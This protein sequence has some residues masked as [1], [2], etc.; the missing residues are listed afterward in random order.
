MIFKEDIEKVETIH[1]NL[2]EMFVGVLSQK[3]ELPKNFFHQQIFLQI[4]LQNL[5]IQFKTLFTKLASKNLK[6]NVF[7]LSMIFKEDIEKVETIHRNL[8]EMFVGVLSQ[9]K[10]LPKNFFHQQFFP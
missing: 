1:R 7:S 2:N 10:E 4:F 3:K 8:N 5:F 9:K 6:V